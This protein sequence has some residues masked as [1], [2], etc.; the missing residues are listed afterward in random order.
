MLILPV[1]EALEGKT[2]RVFSAPTHAPPVLIDFWNL[3]QIE[4]DDSAACAEIIV[5]IEKRS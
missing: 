2:D 1:T 3:L 4:S 5:S